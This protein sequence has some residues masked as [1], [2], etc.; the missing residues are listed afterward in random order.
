MLRLIERGIGNSSY[1]VRP[2]GTRTT[3]TP[4]RHSA[5]PELLN[6]SLSRLQSHLHRS[7]A[8]DHKVDPFLKIGQRKTVSDNLVHRQEALLDHPNGYWITPRAQVRAMDIQLFAITDD[9]PIDCDLFAHDTEFDEGP[10]LSNHQQT[11]LHGGRMTRGFNINVASVATGQSEDRLNGVLFL[12]I[13]PE[14]STRTFGDF[15]SVIAQIKLDNPF[16]PVHFGGSHH[17]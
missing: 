16:G 8:G 6:S 5:T 15:E 7:Q 2:C 11:L 4:L 12:R 14:I 13:D 1:G 17:P 9:R 10:E 3:H